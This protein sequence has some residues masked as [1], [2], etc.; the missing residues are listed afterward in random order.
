M[1]EIKGLVYGKVTKTFEGK[2]NKEKEPWL[3]FSIILKNRPFDLYADEESIDDWVIGLSHLIKKY[4]PTAYVPRPGQFYWKKL[5]L[6]MFE[7]V[8]MKL[9]PKTLKNM[10]KDMSFIKVINMYKKLL[11]YSKMQKQL[12]NL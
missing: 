11:E 4:S 5:K 6:V 2:K 3:C 8:K 10:Q 9:P 7:L 1:A 12:S